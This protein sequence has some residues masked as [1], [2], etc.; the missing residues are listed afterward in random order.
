MEDTI[1]AISTSPG[2]GAISIVRV[3]GKDSFEI[4]SKIFKGKK[5]PKKIKK[6]AILYGWIIDD[7][8]NIIDEVL[9]FVMRGPHTYTGEDTIEISTHG[10]Y[11]PAKKVLE[12]VIKAGARLAEKGEFTKR[13]FLNGRIDL[14]KAESINDIVR[15]KT[16]KSFLIAEKNLRGTLS[17]KIKN[18]KEDII[19]IISYI[20]AS[21]DFPEEDIPD[22]DFEN[23]S[24]KLE[25]LKGKLLSLKE[26]YRI[27]K[28]V[29]E[30]IDVVITGKTNVGKSSLFN[31]ILNEEK[32]IVTPIPGTTRDIIE[33]WID[34]EGYPVRILD[35]AGIRKTEDYVEVI[36]VSKTL[37]KLEE[38]D[39]VIIV[40]DGSS[41]LNEEDRELIERFKE[42]S[43]I[44]I[45]KVDLG[46]KE[47][48]KDLIKDGIPV[49]ALKF[50]GIEKLLEK[51][52]YK[53]EERFPVYFG[54][55]YITKERELYSINNSIK[56][57]NNG[58]KGIKDK[59]NPE[60]IVY[61][62]KCASDSLK[63]IIGEITSEEILNRIFSDFCIGK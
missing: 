55:G 22:I 37:K 61:E 18:I 54:E 11:I 9:L 60:L 27:S 17:N 10:G 43:I 63:E 5:S 30:G 1:A 32:A 20:E 12:T 62:L 50:Q 23:I 46:I 33:G 45:N 14:L 47:E 52:K 39:F 25:D 13:A 24:G 8:K 2:I 57:L 3:S 16:E 34:L 40:I 44:V 41:D 49:S 28:A 15:A 56:F 51:L 53:I 26:S 59:L 6:R 42:N 58:I 29:M 38:S 4:V 21:L 35:T 19:N 36:G 7:E 31:A 48:I